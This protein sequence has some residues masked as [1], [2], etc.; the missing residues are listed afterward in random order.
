M[1][2]AESGEM[3]LESILIL[4]QQRG[5]IRSID[6]VN[7]TGYSRPSIS[8]AMSILKKDGLILID[9]A[10]YITLTPKG[11]EI[12]LRMYERHKILSKFLVSIG[13]SEENAD[14]D[15]CKIEHIISEESFAKIRAHAHAL[16]NI[17]DL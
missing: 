14:L 11:N 4:R 8:R 2:I 3:Y 10:G 9:E 7:H 6:I 17:P 5:Q 1:Q 12:A 13:V 16:L 15:A